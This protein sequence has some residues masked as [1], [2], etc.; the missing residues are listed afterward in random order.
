M[1]PDV[2]VWGYHKKGSGLAVLILCLIQRTQLLQSKVRL[3]GREHTDND[4]CV[5][6]S[7]DIELCERCH[8]ALE[9][10]VDAQ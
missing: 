1:A 8:Q 4:V 2:V 10:I 7:V 9:F 3:M 5:A 6:A